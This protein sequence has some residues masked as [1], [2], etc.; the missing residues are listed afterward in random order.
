MHLKRD[1]QRLLIEIIDAV[2]GMYCNK[3]EILKQCI[4]REREST[5][6]MIGS[7]DSYKAQLLNF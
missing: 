6:E 4:E 5:V 1:T 3:F 7:D 2:K